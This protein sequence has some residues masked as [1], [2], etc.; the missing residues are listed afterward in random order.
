MKTE[1]EIIKVY[2]RLMSFLLSTWNLETWVLE[3]RDGFV[4]C[5]ASYV[6]RIKFINSWYDNDSLVHSLS[7]TPANFLC[8]KITSN[9]G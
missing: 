7:K 6:I 2:V 8:S 9:Y 3:F 5:F 1:K 4:F